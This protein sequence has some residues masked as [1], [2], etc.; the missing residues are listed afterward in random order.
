MVGWSAEMPMAPYRRQSN[1]A[2]DGDIWSHLLNTSNRRYRVQMQV[3]KNSDD[4]RN[5][6]VDVCGAAIDN[7]QQEISLS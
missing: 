7:M 1:S 4:G 3:L 5:L 2:R 6:N